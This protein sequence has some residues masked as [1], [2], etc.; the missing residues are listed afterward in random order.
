MEELV[1]FTEKMTSLVISEITGKPHND[2]M[3]AIRK[4]EETWV[5][6]GQGNFSLISYIDSQNR[7]MPMYELSK[8]ETLYIATKFNDEARAKLVLR[9]QEL[10]VKKQK[11]LSSIDLI[12]QSAQRIKAIE[13]KEQEHDNRLRVLEA[14]QTTRPNYFTVAGFGSLNNISVN[15]KLASKI[16][17]AASR[18]C[19]E[20][21]LLTDKIPDARF[22]T[23]KMYP[24]HILQEVFETESITIGD[25]K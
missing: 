19:K 23:V 20:R 4:M 7:A 25:R 12:I 6:L 24:E 1:K 21:N 11:P 8:T 13:E 22:G 18:V 16:G 15:I 5:N 2:V 9:W 17:R 10:E 14:K 3:K